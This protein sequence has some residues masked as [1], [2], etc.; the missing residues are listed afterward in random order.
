MIKKV[1]S[2][3]IF[4]IM[5][6]LIFTTKSIATCPD[7]D[8][9]I[10]DNRLAEETTVYNQNIIFYEN[11]IQEYNE[12]NIL[13]L[14][15]NDL[16]VDIIQQLDESLILYYLQTLVSFGPRVTG[17]S[18][19]SQAGQ[20][21]YSGFQDMGLDVRYH[22]WSHGGESGQNV[23]ATLHGANETSDEIY[24]ICAHYDTVSGS[25]GADDDGSGVAAVLSAAE[26]LSQYV[27]NHTIRFITFSGEEQGLYGSYQ[28]AKQASI[29]GDAIIGVLNADMIG[30][31]I[32]QYQGDHIK[33]YNNSV[34]NWIVDYTDNIANKYFEYINLQVIRGGYSWGSDHSSFWQFG[35]DAVQYKEYEVNP[36]Y[37]TYNDIIDNLNLTYL[38]KCSKLFLATIAEFIQIPFT[39]SPPNKPIITGPD[40]GKPN[41]ECNFTFI[42]VDSDG[43]DVKFIIDW[44]DGDSETT[45]FSG[46]G[47]NVTVSHT[48]SDKGTYSIIA[49]AE[50][51]NG[52]ESDLSNPFYITIDKSKAINTP[53]LNFLQSHPNMFPLIQRILQRLGQQ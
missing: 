48:W 39:N 53:F 47:T 1:F 5:I 45:S 13:T 38:S 40:S 37:H 49:K 32:N 18:A 51:G 34:S 41:T 20:W 30:Y 28:Y 24:I 9:F 16:I 4:I 12:H 8:H 42:S 23:E 43:D 27:V 35:Y 15:T 14:N 29:D 10:I 44:G 50:D 11:T 21:I 33:I 22:N 7:N 36:H 19:C 25:P 2:F 31:A 46:S 3:F 17:T 6:L 52:A 26:I